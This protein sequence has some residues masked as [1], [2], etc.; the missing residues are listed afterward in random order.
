MTLNNFIE[1][2]MTLR[3]F[4]EDPNGHHIEAG[5][6]Q[7]YAHTTDTPLTDEALFRMRE[8]GWYQPDALE[9]EPYDPQDGWIAF[10]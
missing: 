6:D 3:P 8:L 2:L 1:G 10:T 5:H 9:N 7:F 4:Y